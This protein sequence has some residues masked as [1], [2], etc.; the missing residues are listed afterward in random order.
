MGLAQSWNKRIREIQNSP[1]FWQF[2]MKAH[3]EAAVFRLCRAYDTNEKA[4]H[5]SGFLENVA[6][7]ANVFCVSEFKSRH[8][9][10]PHID[11]LAQYP[12][13]LSLKSL[14]DDLDFCSS[15][16]PLVINLWRWRNNII[17]HFNYEEA[18]VLKD[19][20]NKRHPLSFEDIKKLI[21]DGLTILNRYSELL[22]AKTYSN[23]LASHQEADYIY[24]LKSLRF[25][26]VGRAWNQRRV[27]MTIRRKLAAGQ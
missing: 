13:T 8:R 27:M 11:W 6:R 19:P 21:D 26:R 3:I 1:I 12:R 15:N 10:N 14:Q 17:A 7:S 16:N 25:A 22:D 5:L 4:L 18:M 20:M 9:A 2:T 24:V 23:Q